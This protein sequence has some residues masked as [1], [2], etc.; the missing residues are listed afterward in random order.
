MRW[1]EDRHLA[2]LRF[3]EVSRALRALSS[4]YVERRTAIGEGAALSGHGKR[5]AFA[6]FYG[7]IHFLLVDHIVTS[8]EA[9]ASGTTIVDLGCGTGVASAA[10]ASVRSPNA[11]SPVKPMKPVKIVAVDQHQWA[12]E[13]AR[14]TFKVFGIPARTRLADF[15]SAEWPRGPASF[16]AAFA[17][18]ELSEHSRERL[19]PRL[20]DRAAH[21]DVVLIVEPVSGTVAPWWDTWASAF[22]NA[23][24]RSDVWRST[25]AL[26]PLVEK[27]DRAAGLNHREVKARSLFVGRRP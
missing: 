5:A 10:W 24:G 4:I 22:H 7:P 27:L 9:D 1:L 20:L 19:L 21:G 18:N 16:V 12:L 26:P 25:M 17:I 8:L 14:E 15:S 3:S 11:A 6:L 13:E 2:D 23:G